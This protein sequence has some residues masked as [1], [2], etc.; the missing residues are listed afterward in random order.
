VT[1]TLDLPISEAELLA[2]APTPNGWCAY[3]CTCH[4]C[5]RW[6]SWLRATA[7]ARAR[8]AAERRENG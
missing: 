8:L 4:S 1:A 7:D 5:T 3:R 6:V 2:S